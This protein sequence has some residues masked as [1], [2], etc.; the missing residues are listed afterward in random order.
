MFV[1]SKDA[2]GNKSLREKKELD[3]M[4]TTIKFQDREIMEA[5]KFSAWGSKP[6]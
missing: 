3:F 1:Q 2:K 6:V 4:N 5:T